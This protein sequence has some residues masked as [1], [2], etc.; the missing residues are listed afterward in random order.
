MLNVSGVVLINDNYISHEILMAMQ[1]KGSKIRLK[2]KHIKHEFQIMKQA[3]T[4]SIPIFSRWSFRCTIYGNR[5]ARLDPN[6][7]CIN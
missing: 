4:V 6:N 1:N 2:L 5:D 7:E 3:N